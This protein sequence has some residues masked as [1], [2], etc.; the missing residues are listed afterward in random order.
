V[1]G[2]R[3]TRERSTRAVTVLD[4][5]RRGDQVSA[6]PRLPRRAR[7]TASGSGLASWLVEQPASTFAALDPRGAVVPMPVSIRLPADSR[8]DGRSTLEIVGSDD[9]RTVTDAFVD[10]LKDGTG[11]ARIHMASDPSTT[12]ELRYLDLRAEHGVILRLLTAS[13][14]GDDPMPRGRDLHPAPQT[15][16]RLGLMTKDEQAVITSIDSATSLMLGWHRDEMVGRSNL[17][18]VHPD[19]HL[20]AIG[21]WMALF[22]GQPGPVART[23]RLRYRGKD[24]NWLWLETSNELQ[25]RSDGTTIVVAQ[26]IDVSDEMEALEALRESGERFRMLVKNSSDVIAV[27]NDK[28]DLTYANPAGERMLGYTVNDELGRNML[29]FVHPAD[30]EATA[31]AFG[32]ALS[33]PGAHLPSVFRFRDAVGEWH[34]LEVVASNCLDDPAVRGIVL[35]ARDITESANLARAQRTLSAGIQVVV[36]AV[37]EV[38]LLTDICQMM[39]DVGGYRLAWVGYVEHDAQRTIRPV[40]WVGA[41]GDAPSVR[42]SWADDEFGQGPAGHA[43][44][45]RKVHVVNDVHESPHFGPWGAVSEPQSL[46][47]C[48]AI[49]LEIAGQLIGVLGVYAAD[50]GRFDRPEL[51]LMSELAAE[52]SFGIRRLRDASS[53]QAS[54]E[55][56]RVLAG[57]SPIGVLEVSSAGLVEY[58]NP[59][60]AEIAGRDIASLL[61][62]GWFDSVHSDDAASVLEAIDRARPDRGDIVMLFRVCRPDGEVRHLRVSAAAK[63]EEIGS[64]YV[65]AVEDVTEEVSAQEELAHQAFYDT[66]TG[67]PNRALF[68]DRLDQ[69]LARHKRGGPNIAVLSLDLDRFKVVNDSLGHEAGDRVLKEIGN[70]F[71]DSVRAGETAARFGGDEFMFIIRDVRDVGDAATVARRLLSLF[72]SPIRCADQDLTVTASIGVVIPGPHSDATTVLRDAD[73]AMYQGKSIGRNCFAMF[74][75]KLHRRST[76]RLAIETELRQALARGQ[77]E[78]YYQPGIDLATGRPRSAEALIRWNHPTRGLV[79]PVEFIPVA[80]DTGLIGPIG[81]WVLEQSVAQLASWDADE[82]GP[83]LER[84]GVNLSA[85]Q[86]DDPGTLDTIRAV[87]ERNGIVPDRVAIEVT[88]SVLMADGATTLRSL[89]GFR[90]MGLRVAIDDFGTG[91]SSLAYLHVLPVTTVKIDRSFIER[92]DGPDESTAVVRAIVEMCHAMG[93]SVIAEG[94]SDEHLARVVSDLGCDSAQ[95]FYW[96]KPMPAEKFAI[97]WRDAV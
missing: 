75:E 89:E 16:P 73:T 82:D 5:P 94:V 19:D 83:R 59:R 3:S 78:V 92:L 43:V 45:S 17:E 11:F 41:P 38:P 2:N 54:E 86:L 62:R 4:P 10:A 96:A 40:A 74:D 80:E 37:D 36:H 90:E 35:N 88:E 32:W 72:D 22:D 42:V 13:D 68:L 87:L 76:E 91:Y 53:L 93:L 50:A 47:S 1:T 71:R 66:V 57:A 65:V 77:F 63:P 46:R 51:E 34:V 24:G 55:R 64:G 49:P 97:W 23:V 48:C 61:D 69:E 70:R 79:S 15:R 27:V 30:R 39:V 25:A 8:I 81:T 20:K 12:M 9:Y 95:G 18:F 7:M 67:L 56:F 21:N 85:R 58:A 52:L 31:T 29:D 26:L 60:A 44:R 14:R 28:L 33:K 6:P 84:L